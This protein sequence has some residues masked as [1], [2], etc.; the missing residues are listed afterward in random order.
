MLE[1]MVTDVNDVLMNGTPSIEKK[2][3]T[4]VYGSNR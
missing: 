2:K 4:V 1:S 3:R